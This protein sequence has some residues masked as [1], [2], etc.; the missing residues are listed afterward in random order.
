V[1]KEWLEVQQKERY[2][3]RAAGGSARRE[4]SCVAALFMFTHIRISKHDDV[5]L[6]Q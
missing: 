2:E 3:I 4:I 6:G 5:I 1:K